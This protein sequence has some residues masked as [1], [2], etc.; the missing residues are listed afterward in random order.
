MHT[1]ITVDWTLTIAVYAAVVA[2][3]T[4]VWDW[5]KWKHAGP[6][7]HV[8]AQTGIRTINMPEYEGQ[9]V[10]LMHATNRGDRATTLTHFTVHQYASWWKYMR[11]HGEFNAIVN[12]PNSMRPPPFILIPGATWTG[13]AIQDQQMVDLAA[14][15]RLYLGLTHSHSK[16]SI[17]RRV[18]ITK[19]E[20]KAQY[21]S[22]KDRSG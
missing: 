3:L 11:K 20:V 22:V 5:W 13:V 12:I 7:L 9:S 16:R 15:G 6:K 2:T 10:M 17:Y 19:K 14:S 4:I 1:T 8:T 21:G 18:K